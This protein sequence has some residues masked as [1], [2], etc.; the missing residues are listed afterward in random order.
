MITGRNL[1][2]IARETR[3]GSLSVDLDDVVVIPPD[4]EGVS[5]PAPVKDINTI[6]KLS[7]YFH[8]LSRFDK[9]AEE[10]AKSNLIILSADEGQEILTAAESAFADH[11]ASGVIRE[12]GATMIIA[13]QAYTSIHGVLDK[14]H[15]DV[16]MLN[17]S[18]E[19]DFYRRQSRFRR[20]RVKKYWRARSRRKIVGLDR[21][22]A[23]LQL[24]EKNQT[25][26]RTV[27]L[28]EAP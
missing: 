25:V 8:A 21:R 23:I 19:T 2:S 4:A 3:S 16:L 22:Q 26:L 14:R 18:N 1:P 17:L 28:A 20:H 9:P 11:R 6:L 7:Y 5:L 13:T 10:R 15:A 24:P 27:P 12:A